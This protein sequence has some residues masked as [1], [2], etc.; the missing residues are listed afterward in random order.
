MNDSHTLECNFTQKA[1]SRVEEVRFLK[2]SSTMSTLTGTMW[3]LRVRT[4]GDK[5][6]A[7]YLNGFTKSVVLACHKE[8]DPA[9][10]PK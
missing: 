10:I 3:T 5:N 9:W 7:D 6:H 2:T 8:L 4:C 1:S